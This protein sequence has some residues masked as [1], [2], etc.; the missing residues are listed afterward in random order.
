[1]SLFGLF[2]AVLAGYAIGEAIGRAANRRRGLGLAAVAVA[3]VAIA[4]L[5]RNLVAGADLVPPN[6]VMGWA[7]AI[8]SAFV[9]SAN[10]R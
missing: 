10:L 8:I 7:M 1:M 3:G 2:A 9:A 6:D 5:V 4:Y